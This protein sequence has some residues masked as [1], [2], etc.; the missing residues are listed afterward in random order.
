MPR[1]SGRCV[2]L[3]YGPPDLVRIDPAAVQRTSIG[4]AAYN[5]Y[6]RVFGPRV[7]ARWP[8][9]GVLDGLDQVETLLDTGNLLIHPRAGNLISAFFNY[10]KI[11]RG[12]QWIDFPADGHPEEDLLDALRGGIRDAMPEGRVEQPH[13]RTVRA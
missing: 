8:M 6:E 5:E 9:H 13:F 1:R 11:Q 2:E 4:P 12:G 10:S 7:L 3:C